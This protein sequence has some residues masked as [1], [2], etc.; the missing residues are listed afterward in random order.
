MNASH[1]PGHRTGSIIVMSAV[2]MVFL[3]AMLAFA[4]DV[5]YMMLVRTQL[6]SSADAAALAATDDLYNSRFAKPEPLISSALNQARTTAR[7]FAASNGVAGLACNL[8]DSDITIGRLDLASGPTASLTFT[9]PARFN[10]VQVRVRRTDDQNGEVPLF[11]ARMMGINAMESRA[12][13]MAAYADNFVGFATPPT[14]GSGNLQLLPFALDKGT[15]DALMAGNTADTWS[16]NADAKTV[17]AGSDGVREANLY[18]Q[19]TG[20]PGN[21]GTVD[22][23]N[24][25]NS[26]KDLSR[27]IT[28]GISA[29]DFSYLPD[30]KL[31]FGVNGTI[32]LNGDTGMSAGFKDELASIVGQTRIIPIFNAVSGNGNNAQYTIVQLAGVRVMAVSMTGDPS[33]RYVMVQPANVTVQNGIPG[34]DASQYSYYLFSKK[35]WLVR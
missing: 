28:D 17:S 16:W 10:A 32:S 23:G 1:K 3:F 9:N 8:A 18:P 35:V 30:G 19:G 27:Q 5:G 29:Q 13:A 22:V 20:S 7:F 12:V 26:T 31:E 15:W 33:E 25:N 34:S 4:V 6:Q 14:D 11:F 21:R 24:P 2:L